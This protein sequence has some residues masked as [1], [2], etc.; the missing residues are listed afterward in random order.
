MVAIILAAGD[1]T[2]MG[3][4]KALLPDPDGRPFVARLVRTFAA[5]GVDEV[6]V[7]TGR[8]HD[9]IVA[10]VTADAPPVRLVFLRNPDPS[11]GQLSSLW[12]GLDAAAGPHLE[13]ILVTPVDIPMVRASTARHVIDEWRRSRAP[14]VRPAVG[15][16]HGHPVLFDR[17]VFDEL[18]RAPLTEGARVVVRAH[19]RD[20]VNVPVDDEGCLVDVDTPDDYDAL[21]RR[22]TE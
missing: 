3:K 5:A 4:P 11:R 18:R 22:A 6:V 10:A 13:S 7:V 14:I 21:I 16:R 1:S 2:R 9:A 15:S 17:A 12:I 19:A 20:V 8:Q